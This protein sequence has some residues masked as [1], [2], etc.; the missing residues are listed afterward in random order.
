M[1]LRYCA[2]QIHDRHLLLCF[3][4]INEMNLVVYLLD[5]HP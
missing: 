2:E 1:A 3:Y 4:D 5:I